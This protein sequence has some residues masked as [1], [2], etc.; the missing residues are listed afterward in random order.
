[1]LHDLEMKVQYMSSTNG[2]PRRI[3]IAKEI[4]EF[5]TLDMI[6]SFSIKFFNTLPDLTMI[7]IMISKLVFVSPMTK[8]C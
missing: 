6:H 7:F 2:V 1:M 3:D 4:F 8:I 5:M